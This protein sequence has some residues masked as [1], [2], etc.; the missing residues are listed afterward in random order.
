M[1]E[2]KL[3]TLSKDALFYS[4]SIFEISIDLILTMFVDEAVSIF[5]GVLLTPK[6]HCLLS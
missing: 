4:I 3:P 2:Y 6:G 5:Q 1:I